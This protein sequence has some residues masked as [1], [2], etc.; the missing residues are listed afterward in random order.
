ML[1]EEHPITIDFSN[2]IT[3]T[4]VDEGKVKGRRMLEETLFE[5]RRLFGTLGK[6]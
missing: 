1:H 5:D 4:G 3:E 2:R 6:N